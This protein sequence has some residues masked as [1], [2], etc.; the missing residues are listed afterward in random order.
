[1]RS[2]TSSNRTVVRPSHKIGQ[3][4]EQALVEVLMLMSS[5]AAVSIACVSA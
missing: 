4:F 3:A 2:E 1:M 5:V